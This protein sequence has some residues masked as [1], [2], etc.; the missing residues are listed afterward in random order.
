M[1]G[2]RGAISRHPMSVCKHTWMETCNTILY[3]LLLVDSWP[4]RRGETK[5]PTP[6]VDK[7]YVENVRRHPLARL[8]YFWP[9][10]ASAAR[11]LTS[12]LVAPA[13]LRNSLLPAGGRGSEAQGAP[14]S[15]AGRQRSSVPVGGTGPT[16]QGSGGHGGSRRSSLLPESSSPTCS[17]GPQPSVPPKPAATTVRL[18]RQQQLDQALVQTCHGIARCVRI[19]VQGLGEQRRELLSEDS[20]VAAYAVGRHFA[21]SMQIPMQESSDVILRCSPLSPEI[22]RNHLGYLHAGV[23]VV[24]NAWT[25]DASEEAMELLFKAMAEAGVHPPTPREIP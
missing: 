15:G 16:G 2:R 14:G 6:Y 21:E 22:P 12:D 5:Y 23:R 10:A 25:D 1:G 13:S 18:T 7:M 4:F 20:L 24:N 3:A 19:A 8:Q 11:P 17:P 9:Q